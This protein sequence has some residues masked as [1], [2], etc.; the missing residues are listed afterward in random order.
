VG[1][2][3][4]QILARPGATGAAFDRDQSLAS[5]AESLVPFS[6]IQPAWENPYAVKIQC[7]CNSWLTQFTFGLQ[8]AMAVF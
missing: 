1:H 7:L 3:A 5:F 4:A 8:L 6:A 2:H